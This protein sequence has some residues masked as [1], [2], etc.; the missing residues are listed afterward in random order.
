[1]QNNVLQKSN[2]GMDG[3]DGLL[4]FDLPAANGRGVKYDEI[5]RL[6]WFRF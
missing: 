6:G 2:F 1:V 5:K 3:A 4:A